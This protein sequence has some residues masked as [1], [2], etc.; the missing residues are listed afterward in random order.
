M[1]SV[2]KYGQTFRTLRERRGFSLSS[3][4]NV[5]CPKATLSNFENGKNMI[6][7]DKLYRVL[8]AMGET[9][10]NYSTLLENYPVSE[11][12]TILKEIEVADKKQDNKSLAELYKQLL[13]SKELILAFTAKANFERLTD[14]ESE[15]VTDYLLELEVWTYVEFCVFYFVV[16]DMRSN[17]IVRILDFF[18]KEGHP[19]F[20]SSKVCE[21][22]TLSAIR[23][24]AV[25]IDRGYTNY[26]CYAFE[27]L[28]ELGLIQS[29]FQKNLFNLA[30][31]YWIYSFRDQTKGY[32]QMQR[33]L[34]IFQIFN[35]PEITNYYQR[36]YAHF[37]EKERG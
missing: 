3:F 27:R 37:M 10:E 4:D 11:A 8:R 22:F 14:Q 2:L 36:R 20:E 12:E 7:F 33:A 28:E 29:M 17:D 25:L 26:T 5:G 16:E 31:G 6:A 23:S 21:R 18:F 30:K 24:L 9:L 35:S 1:S 13:T 32:A 19:L 34:E 15:E